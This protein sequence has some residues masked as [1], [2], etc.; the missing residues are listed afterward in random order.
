MYDSP[1]TRRITHTTFLENPTMTAFHFKKRQA[2]MKLNVSWNDI[3]L[4]HVDN[5]V[6][7]GVTYHIKAIV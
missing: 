7:V 1:D 6:Y 2:N 5:P 4:E 3:K